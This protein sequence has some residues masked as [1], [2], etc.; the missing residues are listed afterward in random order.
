MFS[1]S[2]KR[3]DQHWGSPSHLFSGH[4]VS[5]LS[6]KSELMRGNLFYKILLLR[7]I[8]TDVIKLRVTFVAQLYF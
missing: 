1:S 5:L 7:V 3:T 2:A 4:R 8:H 6:F